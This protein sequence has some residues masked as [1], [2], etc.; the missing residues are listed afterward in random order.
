M[1]EEAY[2]YVTLY[3]NGDSAEF[4]FTIPQDSYLK[5]VLIVAVEKGSDGND[6]AASKDNLP[7]YANVDTTKAVG[8]FSVN[9]DGEISTT[10]TVAG[11]AKDC[12][13]NLKLTGVNGKTDFTNNDIYYS[14]TYN[15]ADTDVY[16][17]Y[18]LAD[19]NKQKGGS[20]YSFKLTTG[21]SDLGSNF[22]IMIVPVFE[23]YGALIDDAA[24]GAYK[25]N[26]S[27]EKTV[28][29][30]TG[31]VSDSDVA[32][33]VYVNFKTL[34]STDSSSREPKYGEVELKY[35]NV[36]TTEAIQNF[37]EKGEY[38]SILFDAE[39][40]GSTTKAFFNPETL[41]PGT[42]VTVTIT[43]W[44]NGVVDGLQN[45]EAA[46]NDNDVIDSV[47][48]TWTVSQ[49]DYYRLFA[50]DVIVFR[51]SNAKD[52]TSVTT[53]MS[54]VTGYGIVADAEHP[55]YT[56][57]TKVKFVPN[58]AKAT[59]SE[60]NMLSSYGSEVYRNNATE[61][62][63]LTDNKL[64]DL[65]LGDS[66]YLKK[67]ASSSGGSGGGGGTAVSANGD[68][69]INKTTNGT[70][71]AETKGD[72][73]TLTVSPDKGYTLETLTVLDK[74]GKEIELVKKSETEY[75]F[76]A[77]SDDVT[78]NATFMDDNTMLN[79][80]VDVNA[81]DYFYDA[82]LWAAENGITTGMDDT[83]FGADLDC[84]RAQ[85]VTLL[86]RAA[87]SPESDF[88]VDFVDVA[89]GSYYAK[90]VAWAVENGVAK[91]TSDTTFEPDKI[92]TRAQC[93]TFISR[94]LDG[95]ADTQAAFT[96]VARSAYYAGAVDWAAENNVTTGVSD[97]RFAPDD[98]CTR[99][100]IV[101]F[102]WRAYV[103]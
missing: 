25:A 10:Y 8:K 63:T 67:P 57:L 13:L 42:D 100:Q 61:K 15:T 65:A 97:T 11:E 24:E 71:T 36:S 16:G 69:D 26:V 72:T 34:W 27:V 94:A 78:I 5:D 40:T 45:A 82:V 59:V 17:A 99:G 38:C 91:G 44:R 19:A 46:E 62:S 85:I 4:S 41:I 30:T 28:D 53:E 80:F 54:N 102:L 92:C 74:N 20:T 55:E 70:V 14:Y 2:K 56:D 3:E 77:Q 60:K 76:K 79:Y 98:N 1:G 90:A 86:W 88:V 29:K 18:R 51:S 101:T 50:D 9:D 93:V 73:V 31:A 47:T 48:F 6:I 7:V 103:K 83:H 49:E 32:D 35:G 52:T 58:T 33:S 96:D 68:I 75:T 12:V 43:A 22:N 39:A 23:E 37:S 95:K 87:G 66:I 84:T 81:K 64:A 21:E 89:S